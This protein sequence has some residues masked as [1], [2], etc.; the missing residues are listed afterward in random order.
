[1]NKT[2]YLKVFLLLCLVSCSPRVASS[3]KCEVKAKQTPIP[4]K[5][6]AVLPVN[7]TVICDAEAKEINVP[8]WERPGLTW[9][10]QSVCMSETKSD[11]GRRTGTLKAC[12]RVSVKALSWSDYDSEFYLW[13]EMGDTNG[14][15]SEQ[16]V[17]VNL[18]AN[19]TA[20]PP[21]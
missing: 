20:T 10:D 13:V 3:N 18:A 9:G 12:S 14:W 19:T 5:Q 11:M 7:A 17:T 8:V 16:L 6:L 1:M 4:P 15:I 2:L 21:K